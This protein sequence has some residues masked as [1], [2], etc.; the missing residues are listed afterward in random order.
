MKKIKYKING[1]KKFNPRADLKSMPWLRL[2]NNF[3]DMEDLFDEDANTTWLYIFLLCQCAQKVSEEVELTEKYLINK[4]KLNKN[5]FYSALNRLSD[6]LLI[7]LETNGCDR[8]RSDSCLTNERTER[9]NNSRVREYDIDL[10]Y[11]AYPKKQGKKSG[12]EKLQKIITTQQLYDKILEASKNY[13]KHT[14]AESVDVKYIKQFST[15][16]NQECW[17]DVYHVSETLEQV[18]AKLINLMGGE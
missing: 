14:D 11:D 13:K 2:Q 1:F 15:W 12:I 5:Q 4:S 10:I 3:Y 6:K 18:E 16:V 17:N 8:I 9:T 7:T